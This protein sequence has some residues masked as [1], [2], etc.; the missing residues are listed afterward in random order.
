MLFM[1]SDI[2]NTLYHEVIG[3]FGI[4]SLIS[5]VRSGD[6]S[7]LL[8]LKGIMAFISPLFPLLLTIELLRAMVYKKFKIEDYKVPF[9]IYVFNRFIGRFISI[10]AVAFCIGLLERVAIFHTTFTWYW[11]IYG[12]II[13]EFSHFNYHY[14][15]HKIRLL[16]CLHSTHHAPQQMNLFVSHAHFFLEG[17]YAD[18]VRTSICILLGVNPPMLFLIMFIDGVWGAFI[19]AGEN[20]LKDGRLGF[21]NRIILTP[22]H[23]RVHHARNPLYMDTNFCNLLNIW[24]KVFGTLVDERR[25]IPVEYGITREMNPNNFWDAYFGEFVALGKDIRKAPGIK[26]KLL[27]LVMPPGWSHTGDHKTSK[28]AREKFLHDTAVASPQPLSSTEEEYAPETPALYAAEAIPQPQ[29]EA[30]L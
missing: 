13:W 20:I 1:V 15:A 23:H 22:S 8:T 2:F 3:F 27:Y 5:L 9:I 6:Y 10:A 28:V 30:K 7:S 18:V 26:N 14:W 17:P 25:D 19:H 12:Y 21:L 4:G 24:D 11:F 16:W 29:P